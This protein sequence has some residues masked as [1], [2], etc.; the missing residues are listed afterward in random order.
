[1]EIPP[2][3][4]I[5]PNPPPLINVKGNHREMG[6]QIGEATVAQVVHSLEN[7]HILLAAAYEQLELTWDG[8]RIQA[9]K[10]MPFAQERYPQYVEEL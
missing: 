8:A 9:S 5:H 10:Y 7:A 6:R 2:N 1:M 4:P 3:T